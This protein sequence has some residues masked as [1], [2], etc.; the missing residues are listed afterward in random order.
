MY[1]KNDFLTKHDEI[2]DS[3][4]GMYPGKRPVEEL[5]RNGL[6]ILDKW[7]GPTSREV[8][9]V[10]KKILGIA[11]AGHC[12]T[13]DPMVSGVLPVTLDNACKIIPAL[14]GTDKEYIGLMKMHSETG[15]ETLENTIKKFTGDIMQ[16]PPVRSAV[17]RR[18][19]KRTI[20]DFRIL[21]IC[22]R[23]VLFSVSCEAGTYI[24]K[25]VDSIGKETG[26]AHMAEL[27]RICAGRFTEKDLVRAQDLADAYTTWK[28][29]G[30]EKIRE[31]VLPAEAAVEHLKKI[32]IK[33]SAVYA[34]AHGSPLYTVG[35]CKLQKGI[36]NE[37]MIGIFTL[38]GELVALAGAGMTSDEM[39][40]RKGIA[41]KTD[42]VIINPK[43]YP[44][45]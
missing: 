40:H 19:R 31:L 32:I 23:D 27:R 11:R 36:E 22:G 39:M 14:Q 43:T 13:L 33:D 16:K 30:D 37:E 24:R 6:V 17:A 29:S 34:V 12:G 38:K 9:S 3:R 25:L 42:R 18:E 41:A 15:K 26:G 8:V 5:I 20:H 10:V 44:K 45:M 1:K 28:E 21:E 35:I 4:Y 2:S 7:Q